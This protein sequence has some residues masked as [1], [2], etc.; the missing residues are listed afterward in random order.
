MTARLVV[1]EGPTWVRLTF[2]APVLELAVLQELEEYLD[3]FARDQI[4]RPL[5]L[6]SA[7]PSIFLAGA[8][9][10]EIAVLDAQSSV[11]YAAS[12]RAVMA[13]LDQFPR[14]TIAAVEGSCSGGGFDLVL[15]C[16]RV[17][18]GPS[19][20]FVHPGVR[21]GLVTGWGGTVRLPAAVGRTAARRVFLQAA[22]LGAEEAEAMG[23]VTLSTGDVGADAVRLAARLAELHT[24]RLAA[25]RH[26]R[27]LPREPRC[28]PDRVTGYNC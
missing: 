14:A 23:L 8:H 10:A 24:S 7:H 20:T 1:G 13:Q 15:S 19:A 4:P 6:D 21:R 3:E 11:G 28:N 27:D 5:I 18:A 22:E 9:L 17:V 12:G 26:L 25:W 16:D 2:T